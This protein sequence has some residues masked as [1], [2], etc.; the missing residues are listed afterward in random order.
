MYK[1][2][3]DDG[4]IRHHIENIN[5]EI[6][7]QR[8]RDNVTYWI[9]FTRENIV[10]VKSTHILN[11]IIAGNYIPYSSN[12]TE[13][14]ETVTKTAPM[15]M[16]LLGLTTDYSEGKLFRD[17][18]F[19]GKNSHEVYVYS[20]DPFDETSDW[21]EWT[22]VK[23]ITHGGTSLDI[24]P[25]LSNVG[26]V[27]ESV[28][29]F[30]IN[31]VMLI[32]QYAL[33]ANVTPEESGVRGS[34]FFCTQY[35]I[36]NA[37]RSHIDVALLN[38]FINNWFNEYADMTTVNQ[39]LNL[40]IPLRQI[41]MVIRDINKRSGGKRQQMKDYLYNIPLIFEE[42]ALAYADFEFE[43]PNSNNY[44][45]FILARARILRFLISV[46]RKNNNVV[47]NADLIALKRFDITLR[48]SRYIENLF[49]LNAYNQTKK[50]YQ[51]YITDYLANAYR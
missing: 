16:G 21:K 14:K 7:Y 29:V 8:V 42:N 18:D 47:G 19:Y 15:S 44:W 20:D 51:E 31:V 33:Y 24:N 6:P 49:D 27:T 9:N 30:A 32:C 39:K 25:M 13:Y 5:R 10:A 26:L 3:R 11:K 41:E 12:I 45:V 28:S 38:R 40:R 23:V 35:P 4:I 22:P 34:R 36:P 43:H 50:I 1:V 48:S 17:G 37:I 46:C 2:I